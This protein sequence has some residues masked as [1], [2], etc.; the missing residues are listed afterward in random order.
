MMTPEQWQ[1]VKDKIE[2]LLAVEVSRRSA[3]LDQIAGSDLKLRHELESLLISHDQMAADFLNATARCCPV[4]IALSADDCVKRR[5]GSIREWS[6]EDVWKRLAVA[7]SSL[8][9]S[10]KAP[11]MLFVPKVAYG[12]TSYVAGRARL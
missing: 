4:Q 7:V 6:G 9:T 5:I 12:G 2:S 10:P 11:G 8:N 1:S 3:Y